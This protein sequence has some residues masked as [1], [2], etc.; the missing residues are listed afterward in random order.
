MSLVRKRPYKGWKMPKNDRFWLCVKFRRFSIF[1]GSAWR[2][3]ASRHYQARHQLSAPT[4][5]RLH[6]GFGFGGGVQQRVNRGVQAWD[7]QIRPGVFRGKSRWDGGKAAVFLFMHF[8]G[9]VQLPKDG[10][11]Q[12]KRLAATPKATRVG[13]EYY[14]LFTMY[15]NGGGDLGG[16]INYGYGIRLYLW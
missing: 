5:T 16:Y 9:T 12:P 8:G 4:W 3:D 2:G 6:K 11:G 13:L 7:G 14:E 1:G 10:L 15:M